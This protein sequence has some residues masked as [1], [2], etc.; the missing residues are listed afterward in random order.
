MEDRYRNDVAVQVPRV[1]LPKKGT[2]YYKWAVVACD[3]FTSQPDYWENAKRIVGK[4]PSTLELILPEAYL[5]KPGEAER[6]VNIDC[7]RKRIEKLLVVGDEVGFPCDQRCH[8]ALRNVIDQWKKFVPY[9]VATESR[10][11]VGLVSN[12]QKVGGPAEFVGFASANCEQW[13][14]M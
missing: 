4:A 12:H 8:V 3:Q 7:E 13:F 11:E 9:T 2:D 5:E 6:I 1:L 14:R 10:I